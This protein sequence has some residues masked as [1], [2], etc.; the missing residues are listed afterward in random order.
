VLPLIDIRNDPPPHDL[1]ILFPVLS[2]LLRTLFIIPAIA[3]EQQ[4]SKVHDVEV[5]EDGPPAPSLARNNDATIQHLNRA[6]GQLAACGKNL[7]PG[8]TSRQAVWPSLKPI[9]KVVNVASNA[10]PAR[11]EQAR[12]SFGLDVFEVLDAGIVGVGTERVLLAV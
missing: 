3:V 7:I 1:L 2:I 10:P 4:R 6:L 5:G 11:D 9:T 8:Q 12:A